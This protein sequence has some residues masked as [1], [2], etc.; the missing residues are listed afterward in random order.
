MRAL[1]FG[2]RMPRGRIALLAATLW[3]VAAAAA[4]AGR[5]P[6]KA[7]IAS[8]HPLATQAGLDILAHGG[9]AFDAAIA[10]SAV[11]AVVEPASSG[12]GGG[13]FFLLR[14]AHD[15]HDVMVDARETAPA[16]ATRDMYLGADGKPRPNASTEGALAAG[17][18]GEPAAW[19]WLAHK[20]GR[21]P[22]ATSLAPAVRVAREGFPLYERLANAIRVKTASLAQSPDAARVFL[23]NG[24][25][26]PVGALIVQPDLARTLELIAR[27]DA[28][29]F[30][31]GEFAEHLAA[32]VRAAGGIWSAADLGGY[33]VIERTPV[34]FRYRD[35]SIVSAAP[36]SSGGVVLGEALKILEGYDLAA[37]DSTTRIHLTVEALRHGF[38]DRAEYLGDP[39]FV[40]VDVAQLLSADYA[41]GQR[42]SIRVD[43]ALPSAAL[44]PAYTGEESTST[45]HFSV[46]DRAGNRVAA[47]VS[48][49]LFFGATYIAPGTGFFLNNT[50]DDFAVAAGAPNAFGLVG[51]AANAVAPGKRPLSSMTP[52][53][54]D[55][56]RGALIIGSPGGSTI[57]SNVLLGVLRWLDGRTASEIVTLP[58]FH[59]QYLPD[60]VMLEP[61]A[62]TPAERAAL[63]RLGQHL[64][65]SPRQWG[66]TQVV[67]WDF[68][69]GRIDAASDPRGYGVGL[70]Y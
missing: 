25:A 16:A 40:K 26:P 22:L 3:L 62:L 21:L 24:A 20:Y 39:D 10:V 59:H 33:R 50:M 58:R 34:S 44:R 45:T 28:A 67:T 68:A 57:I 12:V 11:L 13:G 1:A 41:A 5:L 4:G 19:S 51:A 17:I 14:D 54:V 37:S 48:V 9:N 53:F 31:R 46:L 30:Y 64:R 32:A 60:S 36:P 47:T 38:R 52:T 69:S 18:P 8:A 63:E 27:S 55:T 61:G 66:N 15:G 7:A 42:T 23:V 56:P 35:A 2:L 65:D 43:R 29:A 70:V 49:N 6:P